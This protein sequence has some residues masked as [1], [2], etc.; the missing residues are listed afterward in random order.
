MYILSYLHIYYPIFS[1][2]HPPTHPPS[3]FEICGVPPE[4]FRPICSAVDKLD[5]EPWEVVKREMTEEKGMSINPPTHPQTYPPIYSCIHALAHLPIGLKEAVADKIG[6]FVTYKGPPKE[7]HARL[8][9]EGMFARHEGALG[10]FSLFLCFIVYS[11]PY[12]STRPPTHPPTHPH[13]TGAL[14]ELDILFGYLEAMG[15][16][17]TLSLSLSPPTHPP[18]HLSPTGALAELDILFGYLEAMGSLHAISFDLS[19]ARGLD[20]YTGILL[21]HP[22]T[23]PT[24]SL[25]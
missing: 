14:A 22:P 19:L 20:Y 24:L 5:K 8:L 15:S 2:T 11:S 3:I 23:H 16:L 4:K 6:G 1:T 9:A 21:S 25:H 17:H 10:R 13:L 12:Q 18:A 7:L